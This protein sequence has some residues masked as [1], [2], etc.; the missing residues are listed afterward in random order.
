M[1][2]SRQSSTG[3]EEVKSICQ[4]CCSWNIITYRLKV[5]ASLHVEKSVPWCEGAG[6]LP[7]PSSAYYR[8]TSKVPPLEM[9]AMQQSYNLTFSVLKHLFFWVTILCFFTS[10]TLN[11]T[12]ILMPIT[13][14]FRG[15]L[16]QN[17]VVS[18]FCI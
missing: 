1:H 18:F 4:V 10:F 5:T 2:K 12:N 11:G 7:V 13:L 8:V 9:D 14:T 3:A 15:T 6:Q 16:S 17:L